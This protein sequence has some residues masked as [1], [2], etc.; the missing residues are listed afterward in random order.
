M[1][2]LIVGRREVGKTTLAKYYG[3]K[4]SPRLTVDPRAL[5]PRLVRPEGDDRPGAYVDVNNYYV[6]EDLESGDDVLIVPNDMDESVARLAIVARTYFD[7]PT[8]RRLTVTFDEAALYDRALKLHWSWMIR[9]S[10]RERTTIILTAHRPADIPTDIRAL[11]DYWCIFRTTQEHDLEVIKERCSVDV[12]DHVQ[13]L[14][15]FQFVSW[16]DA[17]AE[18]KIHKNPA[19]WYVPSDAPLVGEDPHTMKQKRLW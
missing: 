6:L 3:A 7:G 4:M 2:I 13:T 19:T 16:N 11:A 8:D 17:K 18:M 10:P 12:Y 15:R 1:I 14:D 5:W 9:C